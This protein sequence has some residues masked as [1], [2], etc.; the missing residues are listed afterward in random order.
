[1]KNSRK[2]VLVVD[3]QGGGIG[4]SIISALKGLEVN[5]ALIA[6]GTNAYAADS[7]KSAG[8]DVAVY[9]EASVIESAKRADIIVGPIGIVAA[10]SLKGEISREIAFAIADSA[11]LKILLPLNRCNI[12]VAG[13]KENTLAESIF[14]LARSVKARLESD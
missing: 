5:A 3:G 6:A 8:A 13:T 11:A 2:T 14:E 9:G 1:M 12:V 4:K 10:G 7:M